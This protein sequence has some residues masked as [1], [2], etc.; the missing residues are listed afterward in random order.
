[1]AEV[2]MKLRLSWFGPDAESYRVRSSDAK[3]KS[4]TVDEEIALLAPK[5]A[6]FF[7]DKNEELVRVDGKFVLL[8]ETEVVDG[9]VVVKAKD[10][11]PE[12][13]P[14]KKPDPAKK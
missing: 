7:N 4:F 9:K 12:K 10:K 8:S 6:K 14:D 3:P 5:S 1:M 11:V 2:V 13:E